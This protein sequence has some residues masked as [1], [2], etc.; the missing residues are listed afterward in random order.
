MAAL[1]ACVLS[2]L[3]LDGLWLGLIAKSLYRNELG[4]LMRLAGGE[5]A[6]NWA[7]AGI[8]Y[9]AL[10][11]GVLCFV[12][13]RAQGQLLLALLWGALFG[14]LTYAIYDF[15]NLAVLDGWNWK[16]AMIDTI[17]GAVLCG[18]VS[19]VTVWAS[20]KF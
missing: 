2:F 9:V 13:P 11:V 14:A 17:W 18:V 8:V 15:T 19:V 1:I 16:I 20:T 5:L 6:P 12:V 7:A 3:V 10:V 4:S